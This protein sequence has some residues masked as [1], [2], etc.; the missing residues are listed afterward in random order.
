MKAALSDA[1]KTEASCA[2]L[3]AEL[4]SAKTSEIE[5]GEKMAEEKEDE[6]AKT[7]NDNAEARE[8]LGQQQAQLAEDQKFLAN[9]GKMCAEGDA[10]FDK[11]KESR[12]AEI[13]A[14]A[15]TIEILVGDDAKDAMDTTFSF[16]QVAQ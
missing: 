11:R 10:N 9:L 16:M 7:D 1:Q 5:A 2:A 13:E 8:D 3:F 14:V 12:L 15:Q 4:R 6:L